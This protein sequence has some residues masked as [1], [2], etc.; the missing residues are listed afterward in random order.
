MTFYML[1]LKL[2]DS[3]RGITVHMWKKKNSHARA[4]GVKTVGVRNIKEQE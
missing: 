2:Q 3:K 1:Y 4:E